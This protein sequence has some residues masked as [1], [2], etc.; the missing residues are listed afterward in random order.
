MTF[1]LTYSNRSLYLILSI[2]HSILTLGMRSC[3]PLP[4]ACNPLQS[5]CHPLQSAWVLMSI[6]AVKMSIPDS[7]LQ[8]NNNKNKVGKRKKK[9]KYEKAS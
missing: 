7:S 4:S 8:E 1:S 5:A 6:K 2:S 3:S 9:R